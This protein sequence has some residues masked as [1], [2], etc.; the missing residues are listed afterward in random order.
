MKQRQH[1]NK[2]D[3]QIMDGIVMN[4]FNL[5]FTANSIKCFVDK[6]TLDAI[7][8]NEM[9]DINNMLC[10]I[11]KCLSINGMYILI[12]MYNE[13]IMMPRLMNNGNIKWKIEHHMVS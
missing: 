10:Q 9:N 8:C 12:S 3:K 1:R 5:S 4:A 13:K 2:L 6:G 7:V 11:Y